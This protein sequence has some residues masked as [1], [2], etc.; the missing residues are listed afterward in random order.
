M[1]EGRFELTPSLLASL[2]LHGLAIAAIILFWPKTAPP[3]LEFGNAVPIGIIADNG[4]TPREAEKAD[5]VQAASTEVPTP[6]PVPTPPSPAPAPLP[7]SFI[8]PSKATAQPT[9]QAPGKLKAVDDFQ[10]HMQAALNAGG[11]V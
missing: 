4:G 10:S 9:R 8:V 3:Q 2:I 7:K 1:G 6:E 5:T 11:K